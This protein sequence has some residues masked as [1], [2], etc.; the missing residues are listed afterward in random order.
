LAQSFF[1]IN[2]EVTKA[3]DKKNSAIIFNLPCF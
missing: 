1:Y 2:I 3:Y